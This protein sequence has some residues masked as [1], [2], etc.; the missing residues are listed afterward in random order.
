M[1]NELKSCPFCGGANLVMRDISGR[2]GR[3]AY[4]RTYHY[5]QCRDC[6]SQS[7][8]C[9]TKPKTIESWNRRANDEVSKR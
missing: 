5:I 6:M 9:G 2:F 8:Y 1:A 4:Q 7:G 3:S